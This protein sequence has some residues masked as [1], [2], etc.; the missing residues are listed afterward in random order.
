MPGPVERL[1]EVFEMLGVEPEEECEGVDGLIS[2][3]E[4]FVGMD[5]SQEVLNVHN[6]IAA[7]KTEHYEIAAY[8]NLALLADRLGESEVGDML[9]ATL[10][11]EEAAL[12]TLASITDGLD[13][14]A[15][16]E[17][18]AAD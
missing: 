3:H 13:Y 11:E 4:D 9:H 6:L 8:G 1:D 17:P 10:E 7:Q 12:D 5:P 18:G 15:V 14:E 16:Q 2:E